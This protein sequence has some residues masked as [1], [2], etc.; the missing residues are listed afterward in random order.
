MYL[1]RNLVEL[2]RLKKP[3]AMALGVFDGVHLGHQAVIREAVQNARNIEG[4]AA[5][6]TFHP[7]P[8]KIL[9][10]KAAPLLLTTEE[11]DFELFSRLDI[12]ACLVVDFTKEFSKQSARDF[13]EVLKKSVPHLKTVVVGSDWRFG[14]NRDGDF[15]ML[16]T[17]GS[18][19]GIEAIQVKPIRVEGEVV[20]STLI[21]NLLSKGHIEEAN[22]RLGRNYQIIGR[23]VRG[24][25][26]GLKIGFP[27]ANL[28]VESELIP[29]PG[30]YAARALCE[31]EVFIAAVNIGYR[32]TFLTK[33]KLLT[34]AHLLDFEGNLYDH[35]LRLDF[36]SRIRD[37]RK[38][39]NEEDLRSQ[40]ISDIETVWDL[41]S[42]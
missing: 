4:H 36:I 9:K 20:S 25:G 14:H 15:K 24:K 37:E 33:G 2:E 29:K 41:A 28:D 40:L 7:H 39:K 32:P 27:T 31:G 10:P 5:V 1:L 11:Q 18:S 22:L 38:F 42:A 3:I 26:I 16:K 12:D 8:T 17:W 30:V 23:V 13:L 6:M 34:E 35:H 19:H 21:R